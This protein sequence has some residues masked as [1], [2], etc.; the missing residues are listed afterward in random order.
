MNAFIRTV[1]LSTR[2][3]LATK[4]QTKEMSSGY[5]K[6]TIQYFID[7]ALASGINDCLTITGRESIEGYFDKIKETEFVLT[8]KFRLQKFYRN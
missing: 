8:V 6:F 2:L 1:G 7:D 5:V 3:L 4:S